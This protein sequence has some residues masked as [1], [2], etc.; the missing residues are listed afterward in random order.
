MSLPIDS[1]NRPVVFQALPNKEINKDYFSREVLEQQKGNSYGFVQKKGVNRFKWTV[2]R[3]SLADGD[4]INVDV[5]LKDPNTADQHLE[6]YLKILRLEKEA[7]APTVQLDV[8][9]FFNKGPNPNLL[10]AFPQ[11]RWD[12][13]SK[14]YILP[15]KRCP[16]FGQIDKI[17]EAIEK[18]LKSIPCESNDGKIL[19][20]LPLLAYEESKIPKAIEQDLKF[21]PIEINGT[22]LDFFSPDE[23]S[24]EYASDKIPFAF[25]ESMKSRLVDGMN[26]AARDF[27]SCILSHY[28][29]DGILFP[30]E[31]RYTQALEGIRK[32]VTRL[33]ISYRR[34]SKEELPKI[35]EQI[36]LFFPNLEHL[37]LAC[38]RNTDEAV[39]HLAKFTHLKSL[40]L[41]GSDV[42]GKT[43]QHLP[44]SLKILNCN[45]CHEL[46]DEAIMHLQDLPLE[47]LYI[48]TTPIQST[49]FNH[50]PATLK[51]LILTNCKNVEDIRHLPKSL[52]ALSCSGCYRLTDETIPNLTA[53]ENLTHLDLTGVRAL[54]HASF[55]KTLRFLD[56]TSTELSDDTMIQLKKCRR[57]ENLNVSDTAISGKYFGMLPASLKILNCSGC[58]TLNDGAISSLKA[59]PNLETLEINNTNILGIHLIQLPPSLKELHCRRCERL[60]P[61]AVIPMLRRKNLLLVLRD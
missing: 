54:A 12:E 14:R 35:L 40:W 2:L 53:F 44:R 42:T 28:E 51:R 52:T 16:N 61:A 20:A 37:S 56:C 36:A 45:N 50:L 13:K 41:D 15:C 18:R 48:A 49:Y 5:I 38:Y 4:F 8:T 17:S 58:H 59:C 3:N 30:P 11:I 26:F 43:F 9:C 33:D 7:T 31:Y 34:F 39:E 32:N 25:K 23:Y 10:K 19:S 60:M 21:Y 47:D 24:H 29:D 27:I 6:R 57:L 1:I 55:P 22:I 46:E